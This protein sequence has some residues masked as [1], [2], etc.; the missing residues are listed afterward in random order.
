MTIP[1][2]RPGMLGRT[3][4]RRHSSVSKWGLAYVAYL[5]LG[6]LA[7]AMSPDVARS[8]GFGGKSGVVCPYGHVFQ[9]LMTY[10]ACYET[11]EQ[12]KAGKRQKALKRVTNPCR[13]EPCSP[14]ASRRSS[15]S[16]MDRLGGRGMSP[17][18]SRGGQTG[19]GS[20][21]R[22]SGGGTS[23]SAPG[24]G[25]PAPN[26]GTNTIMRPGGSTPGQRQSPGLR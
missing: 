6:T 10:C 13:A 4:L 1:N 3:H 25:S 15:S 9:C 11:E 17:A 18:A 8:H 26:I 19:G 22:P 14:G 7:A 21:A 23:S 16:A 2:I 20:A 12:K 5:A 24:G